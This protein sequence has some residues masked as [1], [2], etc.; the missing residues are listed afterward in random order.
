MTIIAS[1][2]A[3]VAIAFAD[4]MA[5]LRP[6]SML[7]TGNNDYAVGSVGERSR[8]QIRET[9]WRK[10]TKISFGRAIN[11]NIAAVVASA[12][13][14]YLRDKLT[15]AYGGRE[16]SPAQLYCA[17]NMGLTG[18]RRRQYLVSRCPAA[19]QERAERY[20]NLYADLKYNQ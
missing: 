3:A 14:Q 20:A 18:F 2:T 8:W 1:V 19:V 12:H 5:Y 15:T 4:H 7:E 16:P 11:P 17:W 13:V 9:T 6:L 10:Y